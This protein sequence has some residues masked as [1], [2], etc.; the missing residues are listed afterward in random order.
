M[1]AREG[2]VVGCRSLPG[3]PYDGHA[4]STVIEQAEILTDSTIRH[5]WADKG[6]RGKDDVPEHVTMH[7]PGRRKLGRAARR[8]MNRRSMIEAVI[9]HMKNEGR[10]L[11]RNWLKGAMGD[12]VNAV[13][14]GAGQNIRL[15]LAF[16][17]AFYAWLLAVLRQ[18][19]DAPTPA[20]GVWAIR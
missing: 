9:G 13:L 6:Y 10:H 7:L 12:A 14:A 16:L 5:A 15:L 1:T 4:I 3:N 20:A 2:L 17:R 18:L 19:I 11:A 8:A